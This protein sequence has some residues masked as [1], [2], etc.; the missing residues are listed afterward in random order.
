[1]RG[2]FV[3][4]SL[5]LRF[6]TDDGKKVS[7]EDI[8]FHQE[9]LAYTEAITKY[10]IISKRTKLNPALI[11]SGL[12]F[13][14]AIFSTR[15]EGTQAT[16]SEV[17]EYEIAKP[18]KKSQDVAEVLNYYHTIKSA[19]T[20]VNQYALSSR[21]FTTLHRLLLSG[22]VRGK[23]LSPG[24]YRTVQNYIGPKGCNMQ[25]A[26]FVPPSPEMIDDALSNLEQYANYDEANHPIIRT[27]IFHAQ[28]E[29]IHPFLDGNGRVG[30]VLIPVALYYYKQIDTPNFFVS[31]SLEKNKYKYYELLN[32]TR[33]NT[34]HNWRE[35]VRFFIQAV[36]AQTVKDTGRIEAIDALYE[37]VLKKARELRDTTAM[38]DLV[39]VLFEKP[40]LT[41]KT[42]TDR[43]KISPNTARSYLSQLHRNKIISSN[44]SQRNTTYYFYDLLDLL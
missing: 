3:P 37:E 27:A 15:I 2:P 23:N 34:L 18:T 24:E 30:R 25:N 41:S 42:V 40:I 28:F 5:P 4:M 20:L 21:L 29:S 19:E 26:S 1:M 10:K 13:S 8:L 43:I 6:P 14:E 39:S 33:N 38:I 32:G 35:W 31:E 36:T 7:L 12:L 17:Y 16:I 9:L 22:D 44:S 11:Y